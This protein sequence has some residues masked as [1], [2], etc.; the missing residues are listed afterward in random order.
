MPAARRN[1]ARRLDALIRATVPGL[2]PHVS[3]GMLAYGPYAYRYKSGREGQAARVALGANARQLSLH[4]AALAGPEETLV[5][6]FAD[7]MGEGAR[8][9][10]TTVQ[11]S[12]LATLDLEALR[13]L[14]RGAAELPPPGLVD[15]P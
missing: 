12:K 11:F 3:D 5:E 7:R 4:V 10:R 8:V 15:G 2:T 13:E 14:L 9:G 6:T 1:D